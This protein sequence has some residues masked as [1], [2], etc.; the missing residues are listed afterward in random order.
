MGMAF[1]D[2]VANNMVLLEGM[3]SMCAYSKI[4]LERAKYLTV[5]FVSRREKLLIKKI[6]RSCDKIKVKFGDSNFL[7]ELTPLRCLDFS[8]DMTVQLLLLSS[9]K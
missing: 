6:W 9:S 1:A 7:E 5:D 2:G 4:V 8:V 3:V